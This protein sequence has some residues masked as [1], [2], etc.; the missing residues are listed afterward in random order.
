MACHF[1]LR[2]DAR[3]TL[4]IVVPVSEFTETPDAFLLFRHVLES[5][6]LDQC[7]DCIAEV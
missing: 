7:N 4:E 2:N 6:D 1:D 5:I 3:E